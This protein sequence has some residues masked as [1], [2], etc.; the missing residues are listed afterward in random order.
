[1][2]MSGTVTPMP[3]FFSSITLKRSAPSPGIEGP[4]NHFNTTIVSKHHYLLNNT[5]HQ[6]NAL[7]RN[8][9][10]YNTIPPTLLNA[11]L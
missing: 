8:Q 7:K 5:Q 10:T 3:H 6:A 4:A 11:I 1:M 9:Q 2:I